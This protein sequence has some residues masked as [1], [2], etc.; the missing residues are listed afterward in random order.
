M[1]VLLLSG[2]VS[3]RGKAVQVPL[4]AEQAGKPT[5]SRGRRDACRVENG[6]A[7]YFH[8]S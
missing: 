8:A 1:G 5:G 7:G 6:H 2:I 4:I 3:S